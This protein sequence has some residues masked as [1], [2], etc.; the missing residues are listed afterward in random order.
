MKKNLTVFSFFLFTVISCQN[1][2]YIAINAKSDSCKFLELD[3]VFESVFFSINDI[4]DTM[5]VVALETTPSSIL[6]NVDLVKMSDRYIIVKD[7]YQNGSIAVFDNTGKFIGRLPHGQGPGDV[8]VV[9]SFDFDDDYLY[10]LQHEKINKYTLDGRFVES[11]SVLDLYN[12]YHFHCIKVVEDGF[13]LAANP[14]NSNVGKYAVLHTDKNFKLQ[15]FFVFDH[16]FVGYGMEDDFKVLHNEVVF[17]PSMSNTVYQFD[18]HAFK[19]LYV[20]DYPRFVN[21]FETNP[22]CLNSGD[23]FSKHCFKGKFFTEGKF[24][25]SSSVLFFTFTE[26]GL[27]FYV[28]LDAKSGKF[29]SGFFY[30]EDDNLALWPLK[31]DL[32]V[33]GTYNDYIIRILSP[34]H[35]LTVRSGF[36]YDIE[37][38]H[39]EES[40]SK[41][42]HMSA[43]DKQKILNAKADDNPLIIMYKL[44][45]IE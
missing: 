17:F 36:S 1:I 38:N 2:D 19:P 12:V 41:L 10:T 37:G 27:P 34:E 31:Y 44:K 11:Y 18:G 21:T 23:F 42:R 40:V 26:K 4:V 16:S 7:S 13:L 25:Q 30:S 20:F 35:Y 14:C 3:P 32:L 22:D 43:E 33:L 39:L 6:S 5:I 8:N 28:Y 45:S 29:R 9:C 15:N 24:V